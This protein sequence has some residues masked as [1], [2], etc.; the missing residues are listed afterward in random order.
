MSTELEL[1]PIQRMEVAK[2][3]PSVSSLSILQA[4]IQG[5]ITKD[6]VEVVEKLVAMRRE[7]QKEQAKAEFARAFVA[8]RRNMPEIY[9]DKEA[10]TDSGK[11]AYTYASE[12]ELSS[13]LEPILLQHGF[14]MM[15]GQKQEGGLVTVIITLIHEAGHQE[16]RE[17]TVHPG[18]T[19]KMK[20][21]TA[22]DTGATTSAW[23]HL[24]TKMFGL[25]S[26]IRDDDDARNI[27]DGTKITT[28]QAE[29]LARRVAETNSNRDAFLKFCGATS[30]AD[31][32]A[33]RYNDADAQ[34]RRKERVGK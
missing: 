20:D 31:I 28:E 29:E 14:C 2:E 9:A 13:K 3:S 10:K 8:L 34:L 15:V 11:V 33:N 21:A 30:F 32:A 7:E 6:N 22:V 18:S 4:A 27:G 23:R 26:R 19:N 24:V 25:K 17:Y 1:A 12:A 16:V 5:G